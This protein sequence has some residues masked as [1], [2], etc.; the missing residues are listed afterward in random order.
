M[1]HLSDSMPYCPA[2]GVLCYNK[3]TFTGRGAIVP[4]TGLCL[5]FMEELT[6]KTIQYGADRHTKQHAQYAEGAASD[7]DGHQHEDA[8]D[9]PTTLG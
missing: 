3:P 6:V 8:T 1:P 9:L 2:S 5:L 4:Q 7:G